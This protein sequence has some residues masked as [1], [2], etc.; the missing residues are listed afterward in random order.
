M[1]KTLYFISLII[2]TTIS[3]VGIKASY[4]TDIASDINLS[5]IFDG[6]ANYNGSATLII[7]DSDTLTSITTSTN[8]QGIINFNN[9]NAYNLIVSGNIG[10]PTSSINS[11]TFT[12]HEDSTLEAQGNTYINSI[13]TNANN[14][15]ILI[16]SSSSAQNTSATIGSDLLRLKEIQ[17]NQAN[18]MTFDND[19]YST[20]LTINGS[21]GLT[22]DGNGVIDVNNSA[23]NYNTNLDSTSSISLGETTIANDKT[24][25]LRSSA[26]T[27]SNLIMGNSSTTFAI[28]NGKTATITGNITGTGVI[29]GSN[30]NNGNIILSGSTAQT[31][32]E[33]VV[34]GTNSSRLNELSVNNSD[35]VTFAN[36]TASNTDYITSL[37]FTNSS[38]SVTATIEA[39]RTIDITGNV[40]QTSGGS[41]I[42]NGA[43]ALNI[44]GSTESQTISSTLGSTTSDRL[45]ALQ[46]SNS[47]GANLESDSYITNLDTN[48]AAATLTNSN[49]LDITNANIGHNLTLSGLGATSISAISMSNSANLILNSQKSVIVNGN[50]SGAG[51][52]V[53]SINNAGSLIFSGSSA[54]TVG[55]NVEI[56]QSALRL[57]QISSSNIQAG[58][59]SFA[60]DVYVNSVDFTNSS[61]TAKI[62]IETT[63]TIDISGNISQTYGGSSLITGAGIAKLSGSSAQEINAAFGASGDRLNTL[64]IDNSSGVTLN[65]NS[66]LST[67]TLTN[68]ALTIA[69]DKI[70]DATNAIDLSGKTFNSKVGSSAFGILKSDANSITID[71][72]TNINFDYSTSTT[73]LDTTGATEYNVA[74]SSSGIIGAIGDVSVS[75]NSFLYDNNLSIAGNNIV[76]TINPNANL[77]AAA[78]G[79]N[80]YNLIIN[81]IDHAD[82]NS[83]FIAIGSASE[84]T[85]ALGSIKPMSNGAFVQEGLSIVEQISKLT[86]NR[87]ENIIFNNKNSKNNGAWAQAFG[88]GTV[89][90]DDKT[91]KGYN[92]V[93]SGLTLGYDKKIGNFLSHNHVGGALSFARSNIDGVSKTGSHK[94]SINSYNLSLYNSNYRDNGLG[95]FNHNFL[96]ASFNQ[97]STIRD[98]AVGNYNARAQGD[99]DGAS[100]FAKTILGYSSKISNNLIISPNIGLKYFLKTQDSYEENGA[101]NNG[102]KIENDDFTNIIAEINIDSAYQFNYQGTNLAA[103][104]NIGF[105]RKLSDAKQKSTITFIGGGSEIEN[106][107]NN[108]QQNLFKAGLGLDLYHEDNQSFNINYDI[109]LGSNFQ[110]HFG[111]LNYKYEF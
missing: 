99:F 77:S 71:G 10:T 50:I 28:D 24:L 94:D 62:D 65:Q 41:S 14:E 45:G 13:T 88:G 67:L 22:I 15:G 34:L 11:V 110:S 2:A 100:Y 89:K 97:Y 96:N 52:I 111:S 39:G 108:I 35:G 79:A 21:D 9:N 19:I 93:T 81:A 53:G 86:Q 25:T 48:I 58:G 36:S 5:A 107:S 32:S 56:G 7:D 95:F 4:A 80:D 59:V 46:I 82:M 8:N 17:I 3:F 47:F 73:A 18:G 68:G 16:F 43:G 72:A 90:S 31:I 76:T 63:K 74:Q 66:Y 83:G 51:A 54:Q 85:E 29:R 38:D 109:N 20:T 102:L 60:N 23:F 78:L 87:R 27:L 91:I 104:F 98:I 105:E 75:D 12:N 6:T 84:L 42:I 55:S 44:S 33:N 106:N 57:N 92:S 40:S 61:S 69:G 1:N 26:A 70:I 37:N 103:K 49:I 30:N 101:G 64:E